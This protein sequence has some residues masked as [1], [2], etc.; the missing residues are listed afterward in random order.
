MPKGRGFTALL[1]I[2]TTVFIKNIYF[3]SFPG[4]K[5]SD[6]RGGAGGGV[7]LP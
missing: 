5:C 2:S 3:F 7:T 6:I 1:V 4:T